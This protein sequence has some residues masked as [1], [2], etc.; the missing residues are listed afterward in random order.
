MSKIKTDDLAPSKTVLLLVDFINPLTFDGAAAI[1]PSA[2]EAARQTA[3]LRRRLSDEG[4][5]TVYANDNYGD[6]TSD[7]HALFERCQRM[8][9]AAGQ[10]ANLMMKL[11]LKT[12]VHSPIIK[13]RIFAAPPTSVVR[14]A[15]G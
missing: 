14:T 12:G 10:M 7:F 2:L 13:R 6:W 1:T 5:R 11:P 3:R 4:V 8:R 15:S 9:G